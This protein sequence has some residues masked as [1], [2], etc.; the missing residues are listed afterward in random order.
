M[1]MVTFAAAKAYTEEYVNDTVKGMGAIQGAQGPQGPAGPKGDDYILTEKDKEEI[2]DIVIENLPEFPE[3]GGETLEQIQ[4]DWNQKD[5]E[6]VDFLKNKPFGD[7]IKITEHFVM[8]EGKKINVLHNAELNIS[9]FQIFNTVFTKEQFKNISF[10]VYEN[11]EEKIID[12]SNATFRENDFGFFAITTDGFRVGMF[13]KTGIMHYDVDIQLN[14]DDE[15]VTMPSGIIITQND[16]GI[17]IVTDWFEMK[18]LPIGYSVR[19]E[20]EKTKTLEKTFLPKLNADFDQMDPTKEGYIENRPFGLVK[21]S[22]HLIEFMKPE[23]FNNLTEEE[24]EEYLNSLMLLKLGDF[25]PEKDMINELILNII[26]NIV[27][28]EEDENGEITRKENRIPL[29]LVL[30]DEQ[31]LM[32]FCDEKAKTP[33]FSLL[34][35]VPEIEAELVKNLGVGMAQ[36][37]SIVPFVYEKISGDIVDIEDDIEPGIY[38]V[39]IAKLLFNI[40]ISSS[41]DAANSLHIEAIHNVYQKIENKYIKGKTKDFVLKVIPKE[42]EE[43]VEGE[44]GV[45]EGQEVDDTLI[46]YE[47]DS[48]EMVNLLMSLFYSGGY[49]CDYRIFLKIPQEDYMDVYIQLTSIGMGYLKYEDY[50][51]VQIFEFDT[52]NLELHHVDEVE[53]FPTG[54]TSS[55]YGLRKVPLMERLSDAARSTFPITSCNPLLPEG[56]EELEA[57]LLKIMLNLKDKI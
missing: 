12:F 31:Y 6:A 20:Y 56:Q 7:T 5:E 27:V 29:G 40:L 52:N 35:S 25:V 17:Y 46:L 38:A 22:K 49:S 3:G 53:M 10:I 39:D 30:S 13:Q 36:F 19:I 23:E 26:I 47:C 15:A 4:T 57:E 44:E 54:E 34:K 14:E 50:P 51:Y 9:G 2:A 32:S 18:T 42:Q 24:Q 55:N 33:T 16:L 45:V 11:N 43:E 48:K 21:T 28:K 8:E 1:D 41:E 37:S